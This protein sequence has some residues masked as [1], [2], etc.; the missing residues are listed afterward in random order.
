MN[1]SFP[2]SENEST[3]WYIVID[4]APCPYADSTMTA[5]LSVSR[6]FPHCAT[7]SP[8]FGMSLPSA[9]TVEDTSIQSS[10][11][12]VTSRH[13]K[14]LLTPSYAPASMPNVWQRAR[15]PTWKRFCTL[16][17]PSSARKWSRYDCAKYARSPWRKYASEPSAKY[18]GTSP[19]VS[20]LVT[21]SLAPAFS[22][23]S[24]PAMSVFS[25]SSIWNTAFMRT[26]SLSTSA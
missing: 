21:V 15:S 24:P 25:I 23:S 5:C 11:T 19:R 14:R 12:A 7:T 8:S 10:P 4:G 1:T 3:P 17:S 26:R 16:V 20:A 6:S 22:T 9:H 13:Q 18:A 2:D